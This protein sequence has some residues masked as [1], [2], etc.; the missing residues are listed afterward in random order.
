V[1]AHVPGDHVSAARGVR[2]LRTLVG[3][4]AGVRTLVRAQVVGPREHLSAHAARVRLDARVQPH[5]PGEHVAARE[6]PVADLARVRLG[7]A[8]GRVA[9]VLRRRGRRRTG[10]GR[11]RRRR[12]RGLVPGR[13]VLGQ[14]VV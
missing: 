5:V 10:A 8:A 4:L 11:R 9:A 7:R 13:H 2:A 12:R 3:F 1:G 6:R 14:P